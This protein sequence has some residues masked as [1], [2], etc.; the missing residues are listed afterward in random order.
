MNAIPDQDPRPQV[1]AGADGGIVDGRRCR[2]CAEVSAFPWPACPACGGAVEPASFGP[3]GKVW[4]ATVVRIPVPGRTPPYRLAYVDLDDGPRVLAH[5]QADGAAERVVAASIG[6][7]VR[8]L[9]D[10]DEGD[11]LVEVVES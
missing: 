2:S 11:L 1:S 3:F 6:S 5:V 4:S 8:L 7:R 10:T 9:P